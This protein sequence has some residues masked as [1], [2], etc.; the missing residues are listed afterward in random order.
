MKKRL[1]MAALAAVCSVGTYAFELGEYVYTASQRLQISGDNQIVNGD[2][3]NNTTGWFSAEGSAINPDTWEVKSGLGPNEE[4]VLQSLG[5]NAGDGLCQML[6][7]DPGT[8]VV[9]MQVMAAT[10]TNTAVALSN[11]S[12]PNDYIDVFL[13]KN[14]S[15]SRSESDTLV[16]VAT[17]TYLPASEWRTVNFVATV[18]QD[19]ILVLHLERLAQG[20][21]VTNFAVQA[22]TP[23]F[24]IRPLEN[25]IA[26]VKELMNEPAFNV[27]EAA[28][29]RAELEGFVE[30]FD[31][32]V[33]D[34]T[35]DD[36]STG[37]GFD[38]ML[39]TYIENYLGVTSVNLNTV[40][41]GLDIASMGNWSRGG[42]PNASFKLDLWGGNWGHLASEQDVLRSAIQTGYAHSATYNAYH[43]DLPAGKYFFMAEIRNANTGKTSW[44]TEPVF[45]LTTEG[46]KMFI[47]ADTLELP[48]ISGEEFQRFYMI[49]DVAEDGAFRAGVYWPGVS[50]GGAFFVRN[51]MARAFNLDVITDVEHVQAF[52]TYMTQW[53]AAVGARTRTAELLADANY[54][55]LNDTLRYVKNLWDPYFRA[56]RDKGWSTADGKDAGIATTDELNDWAKYQGVEWYNE[57]T[58]ARLEYQMVRG[59]QNAN[60]AVI[61]ANK[62]FT[63]LADAI[64]AAK[65]TRNKGTNAT[66][67][68]ETYRAAILE[69]INTITSVRNATSDATREADTAT[70]EAAL[71]KLNAATEA[72]LNSAATKPI[73]DIDFSNGFVEETDESGTYTYSIAGNPGKM[74]FN[75]NVELDNTVASTNFALGFN[76]EYNDVLR[77]GNGNACVF[78]DEPGN[79][80]TVSFDVYLGNLTKRF[81]NFQL[82]NE[83]GERV[84]GLSIDRYNA[85]VAYNDFNDIIGT[86][87][88]GTGMDLRQYSTGVGSSSASNAA[89]VAE[90]NKTH[91]DLTVDYNTQTLQGTILNGKGQRCE[92]AAQPFRSGIEDYKIVKLLVGS[93]Y[94]SNPERRCWFDNLKITRYTDA[95]D[96]FEEDILESPWADAIKSVATDRKADN[97]IYN[98]A[99]QKLSQ[100]P[101]KGLYI[102]N[103]RKF[104]VK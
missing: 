95:P 102:Q 39:D 60:N 59:Y 69:A 51:T 45:N 54:P 67:D 72:F 23:V 31:S 9:S 40:I 55:W 86:T 1:L 48:A 82:V 71:E 79:L 83:A 44:P 41:P 58:G 20:T 103:G 99:G 76:G 100:R 10:A 92:G 91:I 15:Y 28:E 93:G 64:D 49:A 80:L 62:P 68:R 30:G 35:L 18:E 11:G 104:V 13:N 36:E 50:S 78:I 57:E 63:D 5:A 7:L 33:A 96:D 34:G 52:K 32:F 3:S 101:Q 22:V 94:S 12:A 53:N 42:T 98:L 43:E 37:Q 75:N 16:S 77:I 14:G 46:C 73:V 70:L 8:Y 21:M 38:E 29:A 65:K 47:A 27:A 26:F 74:W 88:G 84:A 61:A 25:K 85:N 4:N 17:T 2:F 6:A 87:N 66:G 81:F 56:Q 19:M 89:I 24:D 97:A 90:T